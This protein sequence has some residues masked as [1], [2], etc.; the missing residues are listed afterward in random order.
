MCGVIRAQLLQEQ[1]DEAK[2]SLEF[3]TELNSTLGQ[4]SVSV[5]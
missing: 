5:Q 4:N 1:V 2:S 3:L